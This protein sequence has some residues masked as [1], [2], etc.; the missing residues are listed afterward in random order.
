MEA[1]TKNL[2]V[3]DWSDV[4]L[5]RIGVSGVEEISKANWLKTLEELYLGKWWDK[6]GPN[7]LHVDELNKFVL[8]DLQKI[9]YLFMGT[10]G[11]S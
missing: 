10:C 7:E 6:V 8:C 2:V 11:V 1:N 5:N 4:D 9:T 3:Y